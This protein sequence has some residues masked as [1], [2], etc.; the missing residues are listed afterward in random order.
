MK[1]I[2]LVLTLWISLPFAAYGQPAPV[3]IILLNSRVFTAD[4]ARPSAEAIAIRGEQIA[5]VGTSA[6]I[7]RL[8]GPQTRRIDVQGSLIM[9]GFNDAHIHLGV[10][11]DGLR[12]PLRG[13]EPSWEETKAAIE[14]A[15]RQTPLGTWILGMVG[16]TGV[17]NE[18]V[19]RFALDAI[20]PN[21]FVLRRAYCGHGYVASSKAMPLLQISEEAADPAGGFRARVR[22]QEGQLEIAG[23]R[24]MTTEPYS[25][26]PSIGRGH[27]QDH[28]RHGP[29][30]GR[31]RHHLHADVL[32]DLG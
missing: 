10:D 15:A 4:P 21:H 22:V 1:T 20:A 9:P 17:M 26:R 23:I 30:G 13:L 3:K 24:R 8:A 25:R 16:A 18:D 2:A 19:T 28:A 6:E 12:L 31:L 14:V 27:H 32:A 7:A 5:A 29:G 11:P